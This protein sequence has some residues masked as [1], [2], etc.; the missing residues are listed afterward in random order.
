MDALSCPHHKT[1]CFT[2]LTSLVKV[3]ILCNHDISIPQYWQL[4]AI[5]RFSLNFLHYLCDHFLGRLAARHISTFSFRTYKQAVIIFSFIHTVRPL[6]R[7]LLQNVREF[8]L[9]SD[10][11]DTLLQEEILDAC[12]QILVVLSVR[13]KNDVN[14][15]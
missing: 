12:N 11:T 4:I 5:I 2:E 3:A 6:V 9:H 1:V 8:R 13:M 14:R 10:R 15:A 7:R